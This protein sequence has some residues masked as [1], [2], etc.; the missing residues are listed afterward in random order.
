MLID[1]LL[2]TTLI[3]GMFTL[4]LLWFSANIVDFPVISVPVFALLKVWL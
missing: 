2:Y 4:C 3:T 1:Q